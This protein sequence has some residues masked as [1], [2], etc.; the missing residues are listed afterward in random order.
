LPCFHRI[1]SC[2][3][4]TMM[5][6][7]A[8]S[9]AGVSPAASSS[10]CS[11]ESERSCAQHGRRHS[12]FPVQTHVS[13]ADSNADAAVRLAAAVREHESAVAAAAVGSAPR[14]CVD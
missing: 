12:R 1:P 14:G 11:A 5:L 3:I 9:G 4:D 6:E 10:V 2:P 8:A 7:S 13:A